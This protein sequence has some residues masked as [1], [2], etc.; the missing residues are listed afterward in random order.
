[1]TS[2]RYRTQVS[3]L[4]K[5]L[6]AERGERHALEALLHDAHAAL[7]ALGESGGRQQR[8]L[9]QAAKL[10]EQQRWSLAA[11][12]AELERVK[13]GQQAA[14]AARDGRVAAAAAAAPS[15]APF[16]VATASG[17]G[18]AARGRGLPG[19]GFGSGRPGGVA[20]SSSSGF[21]QGTKSAFRQPRLRP[22][23]GSLSTYNSGPSP[24]ASPLRRLTDVP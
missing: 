7:R 14:A 4:H 2:R 12:K 5:A 21:G 24:T 19:S 17:A 13:L 9:R 16:S 22:T 18:M 1:L 15:A 11:Q 20:A 3:E 8:V 10:Q 6:A 23:Q